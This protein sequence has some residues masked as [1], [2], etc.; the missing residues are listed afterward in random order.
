ML[1]GNTIKI[2]GVPISNPNEIET[3]I[4]IK[5]CAWN[6]VSNISGVKPAIVVNDVN[7][8]A[9]K[10]WQDASTIASRTLYP[11]RLRSK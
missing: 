1:A 4:G 6:D 5:N 8:T 11:A 2:S 3:A 7:K 9:R 10:R